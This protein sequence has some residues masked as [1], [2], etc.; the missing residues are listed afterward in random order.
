MTVLGWLYCA[1][2]QFQAGNWVV[3]DLFLVRAVGLMLRHSVVSLLM[4]KVIHRLCNRR[5]C[6][7]TAVF[8]EKEKVND[9][10]RGIRR[11]RDL[12]RAKASY[13]E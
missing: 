4:M 11:I 1:S 8:Q 10:T 3:K 2:I 6:I 5:D 9:P 7:E 13:S 12:S